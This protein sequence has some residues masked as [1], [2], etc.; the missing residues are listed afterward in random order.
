MVSGVTG[1]RWPQSTIQR[2]GKARREQLTLFR[3]SPITRKRQSGQS[4]H[5]RQALYCLFV[6]VM[7]QS[8]PSFLQ[9]LFSKSVSLRHEM[10]TRGT[11]SISISIRNFAI[12][13]LKTNLVNS[14]R[15][16]TP[17]FLSLSFVIV[18]VCFVC[19]CGRFLSFY[20]HFR[21]LYWSG[22]IKDVAH[23]LDPIY[24]SGDRRGPCG[25]GWDRGRTSST[26]YQ[27]IKV[28]PPTYYVE[29][30][31]TSSIHQGI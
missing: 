13:R 6:V 3:K 21:L 28:L 12:H 22:A 25:P 10:V 8:E 19:C 27:T 16:L 24:M 7:L 4:L 17:S 30:G 23:S 2:D 31:K 15:P 20:H 11:N 26:D 18:A 5:R 9:T 14:K 1:L 29:Q